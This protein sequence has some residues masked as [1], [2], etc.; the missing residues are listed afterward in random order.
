[1]QL[2]DKGQ[3]WMEGLFALYTDAQSLSTS[4]QQ[5]FVESFW[6]R[7]ENF[8]ANVFV[9]KKQLEQLNKIADIYGWHNL[10]EKDLDQ[11]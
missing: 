11:N 5:E 9:S 8:G 2:G 1:M 7:V 6:S 3:D 4:W 10:N